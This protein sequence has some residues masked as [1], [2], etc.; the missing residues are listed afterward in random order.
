[1]S[2]ESIKTW[3]E[4]ARPE[5]TLEQFNVQ[6]GCHFEEIV[7]MLDALHSPQPEVD[8]ALGYVR[9]TINSLAEALKKNTFPVEIKNRAE[10]LDAIAD[11][12]VT[13]VGVAHCAG[14]NPVQAV[15]RVDLS[16]W[17]KFDV[18]GKPIFNDQGKI[19]KGPLYTPVDLTGLC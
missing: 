11:Q 3:H 9:V 17:S 4:Q 19:V 1:M 6:L 10:F 7:E 14:M 16:N 8:Q 5:P 2:L 15:H 12:I 13:G 18:Y